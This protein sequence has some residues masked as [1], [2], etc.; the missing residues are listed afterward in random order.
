MAKRE[1]EYISPD[2]KKFGSLAS[3]ICWKA[4]SF[5]TLLG[6]LEAQGWKRRDIRARHGGQEKK[7]ATREYQYISPVGKK[8]TSLAA[9]YSFNNLTWVVEMRC[10]HT[11]FTSVGSA[12]KDNISR[13]S[14]QPSGVVAKRAVV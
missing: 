11:E 8:F 2:G 10:R 12:G 1:Y 4:S 7:V 5:L 9:A 3:A 13:G 6:E 14:A